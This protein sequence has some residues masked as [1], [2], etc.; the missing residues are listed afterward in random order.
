VKGKLTELKLVSLD[1]TP[2]I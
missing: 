1:V 2:L